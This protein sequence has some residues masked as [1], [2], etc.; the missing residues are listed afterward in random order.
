M[1]YRTTQTSYP[2]KDAVR[3]GRIWLDDLCLLEVTRLEPLEKDTIL[4][5]KYGT[6]QDCAKQVI[7]P[8]IPIRTPEAPIPPRSNFFS[9]FSAREDFPMKFP[10]VGEGVDEANGFQDEDEVLLSVVEG[11]GQGVKRSRM[12][13]GKGIGYIIAIHGQNGSWDKS[14]TSAETG[15][16]WL[17]DYLPRIIPNSRILSWD[18]PGTTSVEE[19]V[20]GLLEDVWI[21]KGDDK[22]DIPM[23][24][25]A[26]SFGGMILKGALARSNLGV[27]KGTIIAHRTYGILFFGVPQDTATHLANLQALTSPQKIEKETLEITQLKADLDWLQY[28][29]RRFNCISDH[30]QVTYFSESGDMGMKENVNIILSLFKFVERTLTRFEDETRRNAQDIQDKGVA[31]QEIQLSKT[32]GQMIKFPS[33]EDRDFQK[34]EKC[35]T[36]LVKDAMKQVN[37]VEEEQERIESTK[38]LMGD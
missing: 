3:N 16:F 17:R 12:K 25:I 34:V 24:F 19:I 32:H 28:Y 23:I 1:I 14:W 18:N 13:R 5:S 27:D 2:N 10:V 31:I 22:K 26:H 33:R 21:W 9:M 6:L 4:S 37:K 11:A 36:Q 8:I 15:I 30:F 7:A 38:S 35:L 20:D 29:N